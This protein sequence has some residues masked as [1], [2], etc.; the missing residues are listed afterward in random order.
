MLY[1]TEESSLLGIAAI[2]T[3]IGGIVTTILAHRASAREAKGKAEQECLERLKATR[4][5]SEQLAE[6]LHRVK[7]ERFE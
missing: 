1:A 3:A 7:M 6:E 5:E 4:Q 2:V